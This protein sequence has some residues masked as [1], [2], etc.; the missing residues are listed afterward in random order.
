MRKVGTR[1]FKNRAA[2]Y[3]DEA[4]KGRSILVTKRGKPLVKVSRPDPEPGPPL[5][6]VLKRLELE[7]KIRLAKGSLSKFR[8]VKIR[9]KSASQTLLEDRR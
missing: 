5:M 9:G 6:D 8:P 2:K 7:G 4:S 1:E 3:M